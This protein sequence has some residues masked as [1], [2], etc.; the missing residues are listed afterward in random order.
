MESDWKKFRALVP[1]LRERY[2]ADRNAQIARKITDPTKTE[3][4][5]FWNAMEVME[6]EARTLRNCLDGHSR[7]KMWEFMF[8]MRAVGMLREEDIA[9][10][11]EE[12]RKS[13]FDETIERK[14]TSSGS[15][16]Q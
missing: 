12:L 1:R 8:N 13:V 9:D 11:S 14:G 10:F 6:K 16:K 2:L 3:T 5:R 4:E 7:S 15:L